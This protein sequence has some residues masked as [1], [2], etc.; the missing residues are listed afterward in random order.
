MNRDPL[1]QPLKRQ[2]ST[3]TGFKFFGLVDAVAKHNE[4]TTTQMDAL[5]RS[6][7]ATSEYIMG[8]SEF[9]D[10]ILQVHPQGSRALGTIIRPMRQR[11]EGFDI[12][13]VLRLKRAAMQ[14][15]GQDPAAL[16]NDL[17]AVVKRYAE[18][19]GL[20]L[21]RW[22]RCVTLEYADGMCV[23]ITP[24]IDDPRVGIRYGDTHA[25]V[26]DRRLKLFEPTNPKGLSDAFSMAARVQA[27]FSVSKAM[28]LD[29]AIV[30]GEL[31]PL[32]DAVEVQSR[33][34]SRLVQLLKLHRNVAFGTAAMGPDFSPK[35]VFITVLAA[36]AYASRAP[37]AHD[38]PL[39]LL[40]D[41][42]DM[43]PLFIRREPLV[44]GGEYW[45]LPNQTAPGDNLASG[46]N[47]P[48]HQQ[49][50]LQWHLRLKAD[51]QD[52]LECIEQRRGLDEL[53]QIVQRCF[54][55]RAAQAV[56]ELEAPRAGS[57]SGRR[58]VTVGTA[59]TGA[60]LL[61]SRGHTFY[62]D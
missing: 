33:L 3:N 5:E 32:P 9:A 61:P 24:I 56:R 41:I 11:P 47:T 43:M 2:L 14:K 6:Y 12:D 4:P 23:D 28:T 50:Y 19:H 13:S 55:G 54:G 42:V 60:L 49:A 38:S 53:L 16:I 39:D 48:Q 10:L 20:A 52:V 27:V 22:E 62:G 30:R 7:N 35:S 44:G 37:I 25:R 59:G 58:L 21:K 1:P 15:Y 46:M 29:E 57:P 51:L 17:H 18:A 26:P 8:S 31:Q 40:L 34:L 45:E 36:T